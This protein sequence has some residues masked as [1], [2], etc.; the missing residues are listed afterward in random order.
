M[1]YTCGRLH[2]FFSK[3]GVLVR[4]SVR[5][6]GNAL[7]DSERERGSQ[8]RPVRA[9][10]HQQAG[11]LR[12]SQPSLPAL[13]AFSQLG[14]CTPHLG[15]LVL[16]NGLPSTP[17]LPSFASHVGEEVIDFLINKKLLCHSERACCWEGGQ[18][19]I[20]MLS[21]HTGKPFT[22]LFSLLRVFK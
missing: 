14:Q 18:E 19:Q 15:C 11:C 17:A 13:L 10:L 3:A 9:S 4:S 5:V 7:V 2:V 6:P 12:Y 8:Q 21:A 20:K 22:Q 1:L 16:W